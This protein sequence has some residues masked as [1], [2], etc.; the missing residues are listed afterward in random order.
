MRAEAGREPQ[1]RALRELIGELSTISPEFRGQWAAHDVRIRHD[2]A[3]RL[4][5]SE[6]G[7]LELTYHSLDLPV[8][9]RAMH[10]L[11]LYTAEPGTTSED[12]LKLLASLAATRPQAAEPADQPRQAAPSSLAPRSGT[13]ENR[14]PT[15]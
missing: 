9:H 6:V 13:G 3:K 4:W 12:R 10:D 15:P 14:P 5:H 8:S 11:T 7:E 2:G 1:D